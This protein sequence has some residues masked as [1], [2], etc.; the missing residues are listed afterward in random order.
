MPY[1]ST[2]TFTHANG[3]S[4]CFRQW[5]A[6]SHCNQL[7]G[8]AMSFKIVFGCVSLDDKN[9]VMDFGSLKPVKAWLEMI[10][11]HTLVVAKDDPKLEMFEALC[12][13]G[14]VTLR[15][16]DNVGCEAFARLVFNYVE[17]WLA[18]IQTSSRIWVESVE[19]REHEANSAIY[20]RPI[21][22]EKE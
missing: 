7:H 6:T 9:W 12:D 3:L 4:C 17:N 19:C 5:R 21:E 20:T 16:V 15:I 2:K 1:L 8:Y 18:T 14:A 13:A 11:D 10:F 22:G